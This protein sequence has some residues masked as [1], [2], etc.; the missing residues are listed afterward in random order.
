MY[1]LS[2]RLV[3]YI[4]HALTLKDKRQVSRSLIQ[5]TKQ[6]YNAS[7]AEID[8]QDIHQTLTIGIAVVSGSMAHGENSLNEV[9]RFLELNEDAQLQEVEYFD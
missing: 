7:I 1:V 6:R 3:F 4:P 8:T 9:V 2:A 5:K